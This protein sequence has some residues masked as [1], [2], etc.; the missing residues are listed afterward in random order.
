M[1]NGCDLW[2]MWVNDQ[3]NPLCWLEFF[4]Q[5]NYGISFDLW[6]LINDTYNYYNNHHNK[7]IW[8]FFEKLYLQKD[9]PCCGFFRTQNW[10]IHQ[11]GHHRVSF[12]VRKFKTKERKKKHKCNHYPSTFY[13]HLALLYKIE[14]WK[15]LMLFSCNMSDNC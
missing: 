15:L 6:N 5:A 2:V 9:H 13:M 12:N 4:V 8:K 11:C 7:D 14:G 10:T 1:E 3:V